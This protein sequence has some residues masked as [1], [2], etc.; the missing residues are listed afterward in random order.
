VAG[1]KRGAR[2]EEA[3]PVCV[4]KC[5]VETCAGALGS[6]GP[7][8]VLVPEPGAGVPEGVGT[9]TR[10]G[11]GVAG[12]DVA[13][14]AGVAEGVLGTDM[15][16]VGA[17]VEADEFG[18]ER[19][20]EGAG[21]A[22]GATIVCAEASAAAAGFEPVLGTTTGTVSPVWKK[23]SKSGHK[24]AIHGST[25]SSKEPV[26]SSAFASGRI[27]FAPNCVNLPYNANGK[28]W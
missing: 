21:M 14:L 16:G 1:L 27:G 24:S 4:R 13:A 10:V 22:E 23:V 5:T 17:G 2:E 18:G 25:K 28:P 15:A 20:R 7:L 3:S 11:S 9:G 12:I 26:A 19:R 6:T 8:G